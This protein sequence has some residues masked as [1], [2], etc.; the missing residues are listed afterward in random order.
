MHEGLAHFFEST[1]ENLKG[2]CVNES[3]V[4][5]ERMEWTLLQMNG[6]LNTIVDFMAFAFWMRYDWKKQ[7]PFEETLKKCDK[8]VAWAI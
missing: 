2:K 5:T 7:V 1:I 4:G 8:P 6:K 3:S